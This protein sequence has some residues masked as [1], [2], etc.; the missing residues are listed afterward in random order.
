MGN[1][2][3]TT[4]VQHVSVNVDDIDAAHAFYVDVL[5]LEVQERPD[6][7]FPGR[8]LAGPN[9][10]QVH[11]LERPGGGCDANHLALEVADIDVAI[12]W[13]RSQGVE[14]A[15]AFEIGAGRQVFLRDPTGN[16]VE[17]NQPPG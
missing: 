12:A 15:D 9:G 17:L 11:L 4:G 1:P 2:I 3:G 10:V 8:W 7:G 5:G 6:L 14:A 13:V 16:I